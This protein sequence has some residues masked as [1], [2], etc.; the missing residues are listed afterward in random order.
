MQTGGQPNEPGSA[1]REAVVQAAAA[2]GACDVFVFRRVTDDRF[3]HV[4]GLGRGEGWA[5]NID[6]ILAEE[7]HAREAI[8][9]KASV[10]VRADEPVRVFGPYYQREAVFVPLSGDVVVV[11]GASGAGDLAVSPADLLAAAGAAAGAIERVSSAKRLADELELLHAVRSLAQTD[12][13]RIEE[14][15]Q[16][17]VDSAVAALACELGV[18]YVADIDTVKIAHLDIPPELDPEIAL[19]AMRT[20]FAAAR[21]LPVCVQDSSAEPLPE[22][23]SGTRVASHYVLPVGSPPFAI[24]VVMHIEARPRGFTSLCREV[25]LRLAE[26]AEPLL[27]SALALHELE[28][29]LDRVGRD[30]R[31]D[32]LT[33]LANRRA[34]E[35]AVHERARASGPT[36]VIVIDVDQL[37]NT[38][39][40][41]GHQFGDELLQTLAETVRSSVRDGD[42]I[43]RL[44]GD[45]FAVLL[46]GADELICFNVAK[47]IKEA[48][49]A[50]PGLGGYP[51]TASIGYATTPPGVSI[52]HAQ[53]LADGRM[54]ET[55]Q[56]SERGRRQPAPAA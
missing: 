26:S 2:V 19:P 25:G 54:Y 56:S 14:V 9:G 39:D 33:K 50:H 10:L 37:K 22:P 17:V 45:E 18:L 21:A 43:A 13:V 36:G 24:L 12:A 52:E 15:M 53:R 38:N 5:G 23:L 20:L 27:R 7:D 47:R 8:A 3:V 1:E 41:R 4:G 6:L 29:R 32:A 48:L 46:P 51:L 34:W 44:G 30:A 49:A 40:E 55:K 35:E 16:H 28:T 42:F 31:I 11:F